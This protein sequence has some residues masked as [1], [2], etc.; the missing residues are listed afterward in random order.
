MSK[1]K[2]KI[3]IVSSSYNK[4]IVDNLIVGAQIALKENNISS[5]K[6]DYFSVPGAFEIPLV[7]KKLCDNKKKKYDGII[8]LGCI[9]KGDTAHFEYVAGPVS[10][11]I[12]FLSTEHKMPIG[13]GV[14]T[15]FTPEQAYERS[16]IDDAQIKHNK[17]YEAAMTVLEMIKLLKEI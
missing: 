16:L 9:I 15:C 3:A 1:K 11:N 2:L 7:V 13:F 17:G 4:P 6:I 10:Y 5:D 14:L 8:T 12:S